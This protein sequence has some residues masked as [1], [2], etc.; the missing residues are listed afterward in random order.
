MN[1]PITENEVIKA[2]KQLKHDKSSGPDLQMNL[3]M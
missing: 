1:V 3:H 2:I